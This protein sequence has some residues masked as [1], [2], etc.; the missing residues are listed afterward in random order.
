MSPADT[1]EKGLETLIV[2]PPPGSEDLQEMTDEREPLDDLSAC[3]AQAGAAGEL[4]EETLAGEV[5][6]D[7]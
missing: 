4:G 6:H 1:S 5:A 7:D 2:A 3:N